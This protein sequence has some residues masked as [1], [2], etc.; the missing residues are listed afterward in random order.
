[1]PLPPDT[2]RRV[3][4]A[5]PE[6]PSEAPEPARA[7]AKDAKPPA[8][9]PTPARAAPPAAKAPAAKPPAAKPPGSPKPPAPKGTGSQAPSSSPRAAPAAPAEKP[10]ASAAGGHPAAFAGALDKLARA[11]S[12][13]ALLAQNRKE[14]ADAEAQL[15]QAIL[16]SKAVLARAERASLTPEQEKA[17][18]RAKTRDIPKMEAQLREIVSLRRVV[19]PSLPPPPPR[20][21]IDEVAHSYREV[22]DRLLD[23][24]PAPR[25]P[26]QRAMLTPKEGPVPGMEDLAQA[27]TMPLSAEASVARVQAALDEQDTRI[28]SIT[29]RI[30]QAQRAE[31]AAWGERNYPGAEAAAGMEATRSAN[32][33]ALLRAQKEISKLEAERAEAQKSS[34]ILQLTLDRLSSPAPQ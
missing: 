8:A 24:P 10:A 19:D 32:R 3:L 30:E 28:A 7:E 26:L 6:A 14:G 17:L 25:P 1:M 31:R 15:R 13:Q 18:N 20:A 23:L 21:P 16:D 27:P 34:D 2:Q 11:S 33:E 4:E 22:R 29:Q 9:K 5:Q 12:P